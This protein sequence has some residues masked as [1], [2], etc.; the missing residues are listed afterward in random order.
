ETGMIIPIGEWVIRTACRQLREWHQQGL[1]TLRLAVNISA[2]QL[3][4]RDFVET[5][6]SALE[7]SQVAAHHIELE[8]TESA[9]MHN[10][11]LTM[12]VLRDLRALGAG[13]AVDDFGT[14]Q[15]SLTYLKHFPIDTVKI[16]KEF[17][18][19]VTFDETA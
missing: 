6:L 9:A 14:G 10:F 18:R 7:E 16:D 11:E 13:V 15:S 19:D 8:I 4:Q 5:M 17:L 3:Q 12:N 2:V 1:E